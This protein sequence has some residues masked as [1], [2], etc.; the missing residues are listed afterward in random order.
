MLVSDTELA[1]SIDEKLEFQA[2]SKALHE[3][4]SEMRHLIDILG[5]RSAEF[6]LPF[7]DAKKVVRKLQKSIEEV[8]ETWLNSGPC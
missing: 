1:A 3:K 4:I 2:L 8:E 6:N 7:T 5:I